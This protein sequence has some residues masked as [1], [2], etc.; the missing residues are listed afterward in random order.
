MRPTDTKPL[1][2]SL[3]ALAEVFAVRPP[4]PA[5]VT[6]WADTLRDFPIERVQGL[7]RSWPKMH[8]KM[9]TPRDVW[10]ILNDER[11]E[12]IERRAAAE[13]V[14][15]RN[16]VQRLFDPRV[17]DATMAKIRELIAAGQA[18]GMPTGPELAQ[19]IC[20]QVA[21]GV[22]SFGMF[23]RGFVAHNLGLTR[24]QLDDIE[25]AGAAVR[26]ASAAKVRGESHLRAVSPDWAEDWA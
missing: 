5:A 17:R 24:E 9:P 11:T 8:G 2:D 1:S 7:L 3:A 26:D 6:V 21:S 25:I 13:K 10:Q 18:R 15:E 23:R 19:Q 20:D 16:E 12:D 14:R 22:R 4:S